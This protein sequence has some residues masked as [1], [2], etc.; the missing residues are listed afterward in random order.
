M[1]RPFRRLVVVVAL[2]GL[3]WAIRSALLLRGDRSSR[4]PRPAPRPPVPSQSAPATRPP[5]TAPPPA[6]T[7]PGSAG[8]SWREAREDGSCP[9]THPVKV[10]LRSK[11]YHLPGMGA[12]ER[13]HPDRC[14]RTPEEASA[15]GFTRAKH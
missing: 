2:A 8:A 3:V 14:Y 12:Y 7:R 9:D 13:T 10:K 5:A 15:D 11:L 6:G 4:P 1:R